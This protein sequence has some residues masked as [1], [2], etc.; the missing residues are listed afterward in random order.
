M[1]RIDVSC[2]NYEG[3]IGDGLE[4]VA[5]QTESGFLCTVIDVGSR[6]RSFEPAMAVAAG[7]S[8]CRVIAIHQWK[9][10]VFLVFALTAFGCGQSPTAEPRHL[11]AL[12][13]VFRAAD[14][15]AVSPRPPTGG[16]TVLFFYSADCTISNSA[17]PSMNELVARFG[18]ER[19]R[20]IGVCVD[21]ALDTAAQRD[22]AIDY[23]VAFPVIADPRG[24]LARA[25]D[26]EMTPEVMVFDEFC[27]IIYRGRIDD[28][29]AARGVKSAA[30]RSHELA[31][32]VEAAL[33]GRR[34]VTSVTKAVGCPL[35]ENASEEITPITYTQHIA[36]ILFKHCL[37]CHRTGAIAPFPLETY[38]QAR[39]RAGDLATVTH[40]RFMPPWRLDVGFGRPVAHDR[41][42]ATDEI[43]TI[44]GWA[45]HGAPEGDPKALPQ[46]PAFGEGW[47]LGPPDLI[48]EMPEAFEVPASGPDIYRCF[49]IPTSIGLDRHVTAIEFQPGSPRA[50]HHVM[51]YIDTSGEAAKL[52]AADP[53]PGYACFGGPRARILSDFGAWGPGGNP[54]Q[55]PTGI[56]RLLP[57]KAD[58]V[59]QIHYHPS[60]KPEM[61]RTRIGVHFA[62]DSIRQSYHW[63]LVQ[64]ATFR[65]P[66]GATNHEVVASRTIPV[67]LD[68][69][70]VLPHLHLLG[71]DMAIWIEKPD[72]N[73]VDLLR[74][75]PWDFDWQRQYHFATPLFIPK[76]SKVKLA[77]H[78]DNSR[79]NPRNPGRDHPGDV[80]YGE[81]TNDEMCLCVLGVV[82]H[83]Q[84][85]TRQGEPDDLPA[86]LN[87]WS[88][89]RD[90]VKVGTP[91]GTP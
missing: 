57:N 5:R 85:L 43:T 25:L 30:P 49:V 34:I 89:G 48:L 3:C 47:L 82:K 18:D 75:N 35:P 28:Q 50:V 42:L 39:Q 91:R 12:N 84:D 52:D 2:R 73:R 79:S 71:K 81:G 64:N 11:A 9:P 62:K 61:D 67:D 77:A 72:G 88:G 40:D 60:G 16:F 27:C 83:G 63:A 4:S 20:W 32:A 13:D 26:A 87:D 53:S 54:E 22:H 44:A 7:R 74:V 38:E 51:C 23:A 68:V 66:A 1:L 86:I 56:G 37:E 70:M 6:A 55:L 8:R 90:A 14:G 19:I 33:A 24:R 15:R 29:Y 10:W 46:R 31:D 69:H 65:I 76:G 45:K 17:I 36:P 21:P 80:R 41:S 78:F 59:A 58:V